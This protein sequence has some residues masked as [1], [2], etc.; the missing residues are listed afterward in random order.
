M[1]FYLHSKLDNYYLCGITTV[2]SMRDL[3]IADNQDIT[4]LGVKFIANSFQKDI[5][6][7]LEVKSKNDLIKVLIEHSSALIVLDYTSFDFEGIN[8]LLILKS[9]FPQTD[10]ILF[11]EELS[12]DFLRQLISNSVTMSIVLK[13]SSEEEI[14]TAFSSALN[15]V[16]FICNRITNHLLSFSAKNVEK[17]NDSL[18]ATEREI[19]KEIALGKTTKEIA[20]ERNLSVHTIITH[21]KNIFRKLDVNNVHEAT[22]YAIRAG[23]IDI[24]EYYI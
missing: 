4:K 13:S 5:S 16:R 19:L 8:D 24:A 22:K 2:K 6:K 10:W 18:T 21:R 14:I 11:S 7:V 17:L 15:S 9:R 20:F 23:I 1:K 3:V 12:D